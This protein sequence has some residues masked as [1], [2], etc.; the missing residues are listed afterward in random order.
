MTVYELTAFGQP[1]ARRESTPPEP[2]GSEVLLRVDAC[3][4]CHSDV[5]LY[6][7]YFDL[8]N[9]RRL[10]LARGRELPLTLGHEIAGEV[11]ACGPEA[12][13]A[14]VGDS[15]VVYPWH[16]CGACAVC[17][18]GDE[19][20]C[21]TPQQLG[22]NA[23]GGFADH[24]LV[25]HPRYLFDYGPA[26]PSLAA[27]YAC[28]GLT[29]YGA[30]RK[31]APSDGA[32][33]SLLIVGLGGLGLAAVSL[34]PSVGPFEIIGADIDDARLQV[35]RERGVVETVNTQA[36]DA[37]KQVKRRTGGGV[38]AAIDFVGSE[39]SASFAVS[40]LALGG[41]LVVVGLFGGSLALSLPLLPL[42]QLSIRGSYVGSLPEMAALMALVRSGQVPPLPVTQRPLA[43]A[44]QS[45]DDLRGGRV[46]G[47]VVLRP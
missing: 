47:R 1:L 41:T 14:A 27:T 46:V 43:E 19:H 5:H 37:A 42:K 7:G 35:A 9:S 29:A 25:P 28:S 45:L 6:D 22:V 36:P 12:V 18:R 39:Q 11:M 31:V 13:D 38:A 20:Q 8:G 2:R 30:L 44:Q 4:V 16:G 23:S 17:A 40:A 33:K 24:V 3:G 26:D 32:T 15:R 10:D 21:G 34:A